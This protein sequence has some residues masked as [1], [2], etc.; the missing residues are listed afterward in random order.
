MKAAKALQT[1]FSAFAIE[2][3]KEILD[4]AKALEEIDLPEEVDAVFDFISNTGAPAVKGKMRAEAFNSV[5]KAIFEAIGEDEDFA[6]VKDIKGTPTKVKKMVEKYAAKLKKLEEA[7]KE[8]NTEDVTKLKAEI[9]KLNGEIRAGVERIKAL[10][11]L[12]E[13]A[14]QVPSLQKKLADN[15][16]T[17]RFLQHEG[18]STEKKKDRHFRR[19]ILADTEEALEKKGLYLDPVNMK[20]LQKEN[21]LPFTE[22]GE[23]YTVDKLVEEIAGHDDWKKKSD[24]TPPSGKLPVSGEDGGK[25]DEATLKAHSMME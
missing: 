4:K 11:P 22:K 8:G 16:L 3:P 23:E 10:E 20:L 6:E 2:V 15:E 14:D 17:S 13:K 24:G 1:I 21:N 7:K 25:V 12:K 5:D 18:V 19:N 9:E